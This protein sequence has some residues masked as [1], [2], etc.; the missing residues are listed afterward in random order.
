MTR[1]LSIYRI[2][3]GGLW[4]EGVSVPFLLAISPR[5]AFAENSAWN[6]FQEAQITNI[7]TFHASPLE[8]STTHCKPGPL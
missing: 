7:S 8:A 5:L 2:E 6:A 4:G 1:L 3:P